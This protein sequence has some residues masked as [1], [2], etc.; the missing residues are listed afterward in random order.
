[1]ASS[2]D[3]DCNAVC[4][5]RKPVLAWAATHADVLSTQPPIRAVSWVPAVLKSNRFKWC[6]LQ[7]TLPQK[8]DVF[9]ENFHAVMHE[10]GCAQKCRQT[11]CVHSLGDWV[12]AL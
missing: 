7:V 4:T 9:Q 10:G 1:M 12:S 3:V 11:S 8:H 5:S 2:S 6:R